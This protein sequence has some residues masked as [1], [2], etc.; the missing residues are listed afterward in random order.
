MKNIRVS[1]IVPVYN[2][3]KYIDKCIKSL[4]R[5]N[6]D[7]YEIIIINDGSPDDSQLI[8]DKYYKRYPNIIVPII[9][10]N[11]GLSSARNYGIKKA[12]GAYILFVDSDD[13]VYDNYIKDLYDEILKTDS[14]IVIGDYCLKSGESECILDGVELRMN[15]DLLKCAIVSMPAAWNKIY[16]KSIFV[17]NHI[18]YPEKLY[19]E[20]LATTPLLLANSKKISYLHKPIYYYVNHEVSIMNQKKYNKKMDDIFLVFE[21]L[22]NDKIMRTKHIDELEFL[23]IRFLLH[24]ASYRY[25]KFKEGKISLKRITSIMKNKFPHWRKNKYYNKMGIK[26]KI[27]CNLLYFKCYWIIKI[28]SR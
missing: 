18:S 22:F 11:G 27:I 26:Y 14:D 7:G 10:E 9:K 3:E 12:K 21:I 17:D 16:K 1:V 25:I 20:D 6:F 24:D 28:I 8:I 19:Y 5:Q 2:V 23:Y 15:D 4:L 13:Y